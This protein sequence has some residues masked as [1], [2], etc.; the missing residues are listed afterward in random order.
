MHME[1]ALTLVTVIAFAFA[2][3]NLDNLLLLTTWMLAPG[4]RWRAVAGG[5]ALGM[6][7]LV[8]I[9]F[10]IGWGVSYAAAG[11]AGY[12]GYLG[13]IPLGLGSYKLVRA[14][15]K[16]TLQARGSG[17][18]QPA[19]VLGYAGT[20]IANGGDT[21]VVFAPLLID[22]QD[23]Y[24]WLVGVTIAVCATLLFVIARWLARHAR[25]IALLETHAE[26]I[27]AVVMMSVG[28]FILLDT[29]ADVEVLFSR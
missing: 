5:L 26:V 18:A 28:C 7:A 10:A 20:Q 23:S 15:R 8:G 22:T 16:Q 1:A 9:A 2:A 11:H 21:V 24:D 25:R 14:L 19:L 29:A 4:T 27:A 13:V 6:L 12:L 3:T 17:P